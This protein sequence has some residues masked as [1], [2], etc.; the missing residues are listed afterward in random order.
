MKK[1]VKKCKSYVNHWNIISNGATFTVMKLISKSFR[2]MCSVGILLLVGYSGAL[3]QES[4]FDQSDNINLALRHTGHLLYESCG[5][6]NSQIPPV[7]QTS[8]TEYKLRLKNGFEYDSL[9]EILDRSLKQFGITNSY[10]VFILTCESESIVL[11]YNDLSFQNKVV[12]CS[13]R[14]QDNLCKIIN[15]KIEQELSVENNQDYSI[16]WLLLVGIIPLIVFL[17]NRKKIEAPIEEELQERVNDNHL[18]VGN[19]TFDSQS[20]TLSY[21]GESK[22]LTFREGKLFEYFILHKNEVLKRE[23]I[24]NHVWEDEGVIVGRSLDVFIS[25][26]R[27]IIKEDTSLAIKNIHGVGYRLEVK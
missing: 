4:A 15:L 12:A 19:S 3:C 10:T 22:D 26:L 8:D 9:P 7:E 11:G 1:N 16:F 21:N 20:L 25:R 27:K 14:E 18:I 23:D 13:S 5:D 6:N 2:V 17:I 24:Q